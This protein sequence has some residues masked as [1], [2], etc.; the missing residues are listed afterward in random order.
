VRG[1][2]FTHLI[3]TR[4]DYRPDHPALAERVRLFRELTVPSIA[5]QTCQRFTWIVETKNAEFREALQ[6]LPNAFFSVRPLS[7][8]VLE[9]L[10]VDPWLITSR[11]DN[12][13][14][15]LP[16]YVERVQAEFRTERAAI[17]SRGYRWN[18][19]TG[20][21]VHF[22]HYRADFTSPFAS[23]IE[24]AKGAVGVRSVHHH[25]LRKLA[26]V[27]VLEARLWVQVI[28]GGNLQMKWLDGH[29]PATEEEARR[30]RGLRAA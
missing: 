30:V 16:E 1:V 13:D 28:H 14:V 18:T 22:D 15:L 23:L 24:P 9:T 5:A 10:A 8:V 3:L 17:D 7:S 27:T 4:S 6:G 29:E 11:V 26:P 20:E 19:A 2:T 12:D 25:A 21:V